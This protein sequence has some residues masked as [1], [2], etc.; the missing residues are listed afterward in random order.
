MGFWLEA[1][2]QAFP[3]HIIGFFNWQFGGAADNAFRITHAANNACA[4]NRNRQQSAKAR[5]KGPFW[6]KNI[7]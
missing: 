2:K 3:A 5:D 6:A 7:A 4:Q 1:A